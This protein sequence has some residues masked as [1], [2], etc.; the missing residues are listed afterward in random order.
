MKIPITILLRK[1]TKQALLEYKED[2][3]NK[4]IRLSLSYIVEDAIILFLS[5][6]GVGVQF[7]ENPETL[8]E[9]KEDI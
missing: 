2:L 8:H 5:E 6:N 9:Y 4:G 3:K 1:P 7:E